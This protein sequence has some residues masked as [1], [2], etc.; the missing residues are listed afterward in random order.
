M[1]KV[2]SNVLIAL[3]KGIVYSHQEE[4]WNTLILP[5][6]ERDVRNY[7]ADIHLDLIIDKSEG[8]AYLKQQQT[9]A[10]EGENEQETPMKLIR[11]RAL[12]FHVS[13]LCLLLRK[14]LIE[15]DQT[16]ES[17][18]AILSREEINSQMKLYMKES[19]NEAVVN[20][21]IDAAIKKVEDEGFL[22]RMKTEQEQYEVN[23][24]IKAFVNAD[25]VSEWLERYKEYV[26]QSK[27]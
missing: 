24:I 12:T 13:L 19:T 10:D 26:K 2:Y 7:F 18:R 22:R 8:Y 3:L 25:Q 15:N 27:K 20:K 1:K 5:E 17:T 4:I 21:Q 9:S 6:N 16:G 11:R 14:H 23:R